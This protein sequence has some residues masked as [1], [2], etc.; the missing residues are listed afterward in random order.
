MGA[1][2]FPWQVTPLCLSEARP[3]CEAVV[4]NAGPWSRVC[5][6]AAWAKPVVF[7]RFWGKWRPFFERN[8]LAQNE[9]QT[10]L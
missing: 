7:V 1:A 6:S 4:V 5:A 2:G 8:S 10:A 3:T 9:I